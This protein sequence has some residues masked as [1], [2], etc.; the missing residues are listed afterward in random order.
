MRSVS[1]GAAKIPILAMGL[2]ELSAHHGA[3][4]IARSAGRLGI[5]VYH[6]HQGSPS[7]LYASRYSHRALTLPA[8]ADAER[9]L[10]VL[11]AFA[12]RAGPAVLVAVDD[13]SAVFVDEHADTLRG[14]FVFPSQPAGLVGALCSKRELLALC[15]RHG[16][17]SPRS[18]FPT[19]AE[20][21]EGCIEQMGLPLMV[22][23]IA[24]PNPGGEPAPSVMLARDPRELLEA[25]RLMG[26]AG[27]SN[28]MVQELIPGQPESLWM[29][30]GYFDAHSKPLVAFTGVKLR[31]APPDTG[32]TTLGV[33]RANPEIANT[34]IRFM[35]AL[36]YRGM[37]DMDYCRDPRDGRYKLL[38]AN[39]RIG[40]TFRL[41]VDTQGV[42]V[43]RAMYLDLTGEPVSSGVQRQGRRW[44]AEPLDL[45]SSL[46]YLR[47]GELTARTWLRSL[48]GVQEAAWWAADDP[49]PLPSVFLRL[50]G[51]R[52][53][54]ALFGRR[55]RQRDGRA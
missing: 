13:A 16:V 41:F 27:V 9:R 25:Y 50:F 43:L 28:A 19:S 53:R 34:T 48:R 8:D 14:S 52:L 30:N 4:G 49:L 3:I 45:R 55:T 24:P 29:F 15:A 22:K 6:L 1:G 33:C 47:R 21:L 7:R 38:D 44:V 36:G 32:A 20:E 54:R 39:P 10:E 40:A 23:R 11:L 42:D 18:A 17:A 31:Q 12:A 46:I 35:Q 51:A 5:P 26:S 37:L 2:T